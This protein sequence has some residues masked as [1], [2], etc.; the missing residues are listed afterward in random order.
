MSGCGDRGCAIVAGAPAFWQTLRILSA[1]AVAY[2]VAALVGLPDRF[3]A[4]VTAVVVT[5]PA[6][7]ATLSAGRDRIVGTMLG[8]LAG[9]G[10]IEA[11]R[12]GWPLFAMFWVA[13]VPLAILTALWPNLR[14]GCI[15]LVVVVLVPSSGGLSFARPLDRVLEI[16]LGTLVSIAVSVVIFPGRAPKGK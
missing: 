15:T 12:H 13:L 9:L 6:L 7:D 2:G 4:M 3:W 16:L 5:Q 11:A 10:V 14:L 8:A 1:C